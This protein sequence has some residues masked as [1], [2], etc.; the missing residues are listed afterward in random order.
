MESIEVV[1]RFD[2]QGKVYPLSLRWQGRDYLVEA[3]GRRWQAADGL[4]ILLLTP[5]GRAFEVRYL[6]ADN[7]WFMVKAPSDRIL[8]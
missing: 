6:A 7:L 4:H 2:Q 5:S 8:A 3:T 1:A